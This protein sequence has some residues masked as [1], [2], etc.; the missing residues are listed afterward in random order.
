VARA[1]IARLLELNQLRNVT[2]QIT[3]QFFTGHPALGAP[4]TLLRFAPFGMP[5]IVYQST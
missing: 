2:L 4:F 1:Q 3:P 5:D